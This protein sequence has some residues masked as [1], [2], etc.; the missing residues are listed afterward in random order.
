M[1]SLVSNLLRLRAMSYLPLPSPVNKNA[2]QVEPPLHFVLQQQRGERGKE[3]TLQY[4][5]TLTPLPSSADEDPP[6]EVT[7]RIDKEIRALLSPE[8]G[9]TIM[10]EVRILES[11][12]Q[13]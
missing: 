2:L 7:A 11:R 5:L 12:V 1:T 9:R 6:W 8:V 3:T 13:P 10:T 4:T